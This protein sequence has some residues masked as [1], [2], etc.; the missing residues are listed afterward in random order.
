[1][2]NQYLVCEEYTPGDASYSNIGRV[3][4]K[5]KHENDAIAFM[6]N[7]KN[8]QQ[9]YGLSLYRKSAADVLYRWD[10]QGGWEVC[11]CG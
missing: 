7:D 4:K 10:G 11:S 2:K 9:Y 6:E 8:A 5:F 3:I 1:M